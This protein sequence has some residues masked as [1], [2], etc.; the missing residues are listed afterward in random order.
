MGWMNGEQ[1]ELEFS[2]ELD[3]E[4]GQLHAKAGS[5]PRPQLLQAAQAGVLHPEQAEAITRHIEGCRLCESLL[6][7]LEGLDDLELDKA[8]RE[9]IWNRVQKE[10]RPQTSSVKRAGF[11]WNW[12]LRPLP[13]AALASVIVLAIGLTFVLPRRTPVSVAQNQ[14]PPVSPAAAS[15]FKLEKAPVMLPAAA[16]VWRGQEDIP[17]KQARE[18][19]QALVPYEAGNYGSAVKGLDVLRRK[20]PRMAEASF[21]LGVCRLF[22]NQNEEAAVALKD[23]VNLGVPP[24]SDQA[25]WY[26]AFAYYQTGKRDLASGLLQPLCKTKGQDSARACAAVKEL[27]ERH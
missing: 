3:G 22:L 1:A 4:L 23:A 16:I 6:S 24:L 27:E 26:L 21:Y 8:S 2:N 13:V 9:K 15:V 14:Q 25:T 12:W 18:L 7:D 11:S 5:C 19:E 10:A 17:S 20:Y